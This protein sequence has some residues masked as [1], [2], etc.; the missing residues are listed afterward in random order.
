MAAGKLKKLAVIGGGP[1]GVAIAIKAHALNKV[2]S[3]RLQVEIFERDEIGSHWRG[4]VGYTDGEQELCTPAFRDLGFPYTPEKRVPAKVQDYCHAELSWSAF[5][6]ADGTYRDWINH[7]CPRP[8]HGDFADYLQWAAVKARCKITQTDVTGLEPKGSK[9]TLFAGA[10]RSRI[11]LGDFDGVVVTGPGPPRNARATPHPQIFDG[12]DFWSRT[13]EVRAALKNALPDDEIVIAGAGGTAAAIIAW[14]AR[15]GYK[16][17]PIIVVSVQP[18]LFTRGESFFEE[19]LFS[20]EAAW[21]ALSPASRK[22]FSERLTRGVVWRA[23]MPQIS[24]MS[25]TFVD[26]RMHAIDDSGAGRRG[27]VSLIAQD[28]LGARTPFPG[29]IVI[30]ALGF[31]SWWFL[32]L[33]PTTAFPFGVSETAQES[34]KQG[35]NRHLAF[36]SGWTLPPLH[37]PFLAEKI[38]PGFG[39]LLALGD[40]SNRVVASYI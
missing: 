9:W 16:S 33:L 34:L 8:T 15:A 37:A 30:N 32:K 5:K 36:E 40:M 28:H 6:V 11:S 20:N 1:K 4:A 18:T 2:T 3:R 24:K 10:G 35:M 17:H 13:D 14:L 21:A 22:L 39:S 29:A 26:R 27:Q 19:D 31:D 38:G 7:G 25:L 23:V 12:R